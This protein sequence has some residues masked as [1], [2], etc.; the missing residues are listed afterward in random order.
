MNTVIPIIITVPDVPEEIYDWDH[1]ARC[2]YVECVKRGAQT[3][4]RGR[5]MIVGCAGAGKT[6][7]LRR[8][9]KQGLEQ[10]KQVESTVGLEVHEDL[11]E[12]TATWRLRG[13]Y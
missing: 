7:L 1:E 11:F 12:I 8:L 9:Q 10:L 3:V 5:M 4:H 6:T 2:R 13:I